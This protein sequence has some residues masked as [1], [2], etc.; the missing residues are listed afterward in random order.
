MRIVLSDL[1]SCVTETS[2]F[3]P[4]LPEKQMIVKFVGTENIFFLMFF[5]V[6]RCFVRVT[7][8]MHAAEEATM[9]NER[10]TC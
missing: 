2:F 10:L 9:L 4:Q 7:G 5:M 8:W 3:S 6:V 1:I